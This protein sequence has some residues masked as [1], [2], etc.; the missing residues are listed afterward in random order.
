MPT[1]G[2]ARVSTDGQSLGAQH[3][4]LHAAGC[5]KVYAEKISGARSNRPEL[6]KAR[7]V[8]FGR[9]APLT[10][11]QPQEALQ[12]LGNGEAQADLA[13]SYGV[14]QATISRLQRFTNLV[15]IIDHETHNSRWPFS[16]VST[17]SCGR[18]HLPQN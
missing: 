17:V 4:Q 10:A 12:R 6:A 7:G 3:A 13:R 2:Y 15:R 5:V 11:H 1:Y 8:K 9:P 14:S 18:S 16:S